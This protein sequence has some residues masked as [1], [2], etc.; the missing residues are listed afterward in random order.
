[1]RRILGFT[2]LVLAVGVVVVLGTGASS[3]G[4]GGGQG[5]VYK[6]ELDNAFGLTE[7]GDFKIAG[8]RAGKIKTLELDMRTSRRPSSPLRAQ[9]LLRVS[10]RGEIELGEDT[11]DRFEPDQPLALEYRQHA[12]DRF[13]GEPEIIGDVGPAHRQVEAACPAF[14]DPVGA[15]DAAGSFGGIYQSAVYSYGPELIREPAPAE[16]F[17]AG[18]EE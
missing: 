3:N 1:M 7:G 14:A 16:R 17:V 8:V 4:D 9:H 18:A 2:L 10:P 15:I 5:N 11:V 13:L 6:V 12:A